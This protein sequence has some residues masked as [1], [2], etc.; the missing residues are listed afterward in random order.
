MDQE[1]PPSEHT[2][3]PRGFIVST[4]EVAVPKNYRKVTFKGLYVYVDAAC[5]VYSSI[6]GKS[7]V[8]VFGTIFDNECPDSTPEEV[9]AGLSAILSRGRAQFF[10]SLYSLGGRHAIFCMD[11][12][13]CFAVGDA[14]GARSIF[15]KM[16]GANFILSSHAQ[17]LAQ[18]INAPISQFSD[19]IQSLGTTYRARNWPGRQSRFD[20][21]LQLTPNTTINLKSGKVS[22]FFGKD[23]PPLR[24]AEEAAAIARKHL[25]NSVS[26]FSKHYLQG[27]SKAALF[28]TSG[29][30][31][32]LVVSSFKYNYENLEAVTYRLGEVH[33]GDVRIATKIT[34]SLGIKHRVLSCEIGC[35]GSLQDWCEVN[36]SNVYVGSRKVIED[37]VGSFDG[38]GVEF[39]VRGNLGE[40]SRGVFLA[41]PAFKDVPP[42]F[43]ARN[44]YRG[45]DVHDSVIEAFRDFSDA[46]EM[47]SIQWPIRVLYY[48]EHKH[49]T[50]FSATLNE[51]DVAFDTFVPMNSRNIIEAMCGVSESDQ[52]SDAVHKEMI[53]ALRP[54]LLEIEIN[55]GKYN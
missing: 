41:R 4:S 10:K 34:D 52:E 53:R 20:G 21:V 3:Y 33:D 8:V 25:V 12:Q 40:I 15:Y 32:R 18:Q 37:V 26:A 54:D 2:N 55:P 49:A 24:P 19:N 1:M 47:E 16:V 38:Q 13:G 5:Y 39:S 36:G 45:S 42:R 44:W 31:S 22:R 48:W 14:G 6:D 30:D 23:A 17:L 51:M 11:S 43:M 50:W 35:G 9:A 46:I 28:L 27:R 29:I 7:R